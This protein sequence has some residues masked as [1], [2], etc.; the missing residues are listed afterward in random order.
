MLSAHVS[1]RIPP[2]FSPLSF[3]LQFDLVRVTVLYARCFCHSQCTSQNVLSRFK[4]EKKKSSVTVYFD[5]SMYI[6][7]ACAAVVAKSQSP[8][9]KR[10]VVFVAY[11]MYCTLFEKFIGFVSN[12]AEF[13]CENIDKMLSLHTCGHSFELF[14]INIASH[15]KYSTTIDQN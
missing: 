11:N 12:G 1:N 4:G 6:C 14:Y 9:N 7:S 3:S 8:A 2:Y 13:Q 5:K 10:I 15:S